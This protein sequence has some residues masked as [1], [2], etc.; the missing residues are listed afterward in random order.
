[1]VDTVL[2]TEALAGCIGT[3]FMDADAFGGVIIVVLVIACGVKAGA[4]LLS[5]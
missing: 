1:M 2:A 5:L 4:F 3:I